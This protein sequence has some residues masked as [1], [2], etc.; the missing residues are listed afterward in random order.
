[1]SVL[2]TSDAKVIYKEV[3]EVIKKYIITKKG[4]EKFSPDLFSD[5]K[6]ILAM[7]NKIS[8]YSRID[9]A[10]IDKIRENL[11]DFE[12]KKAGDFFV[13]RVVIVPDDESYE[14]FMWLKKYCDLRISNSNEDIDE[15]QQIVMANPD[16]PVE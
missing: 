9:S 12:L 2:K 15:R 10:T 8:K 4:R 13:D 16:M 11:T 6:D 3:S 7:Q 1:M 5:A 14:R